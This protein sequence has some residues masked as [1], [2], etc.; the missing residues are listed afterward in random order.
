MPGKVIHTQTSLKRALDVAQ[1]RWEQDYIE[2]TQNFVRKLEV[3]GQ[4]GGPQETIQT[5]I[6]DA[7]SNPVYRNALAHFNAVQD[8]RDDEAQRLANQ[9]SERVLFEDDFKATA[10][11]E[12]WITS[13]TDS[14]LLGQG[15]LQAFDADTKLMLAQ[16]FSGNF[17]IDLMIEKS[18]EKNQADWDFGIDLKA[19]NASTTLHFSGNRLQTLT[20]NEDEIQLEATSPIS[21][22]GTLSLSHREG[23]IRAEYTDAAG[24]TLATS[25]KIVPRWVRRRTSPAVVRWRSST[26]RAAWRT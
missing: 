18:G 8:G 24:Q 14:V 10:L 6:A 19:I 13:Q 5:L 11:S 15:K 9:K 25:W 17:R 4:N 7:S 1:L 21:H 26:T 3:L 16:K 2:A 12:R 20:L 22:P 23:K